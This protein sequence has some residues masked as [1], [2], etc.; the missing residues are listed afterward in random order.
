MLK[1]LRIDKQYFGKGGSPIATSRPQH[2]KVFGVVMKPSTFSYRTSWNINSTSTTPQLQGFLLQMTTETNKNAAQDT[3]VAQQS[4]CQLRVFVRGPPDQ[5]GQLFLENIPVT[6]TLTY[7]TYI[8]KDMF[9]TKTH[10]HMYVNMC[11]YEMD[12]I[13]EHDEI[14]H[15]AMKKNIHTLVYGA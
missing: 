8:R 4:L 7:F 2:L 14:W 5:W 12:T 13:V 3:A 10:T 15:I 9:K 6:Y 1:G 11:I